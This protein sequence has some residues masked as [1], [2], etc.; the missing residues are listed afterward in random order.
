MGCG[1][2]LSNFL[3]IQMRKRRLEGQRCFSA[4]IHPTPTQ[5][6]RQR[7]E[8]G[9]QW[10]AGILTDMVAAPDGSPRWL[11]EI[12]AQTLTSQ[13]SLYPRVLHINSPKAINEDF[14]P[15]C[16]GVSPPTS[17]GTQN[18]QAEGSSPRPSPLSPEHPP[19]L[20]PAQLPS[21]LLDLEGM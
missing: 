2:D 18:K 3:S 14:G 6:K 13:S 17:P 1:G 16:Q 10:G 7:V 12:W 4:S 20:P 11:L 15:F 19:G 9:G 8:G 5:A 21:L